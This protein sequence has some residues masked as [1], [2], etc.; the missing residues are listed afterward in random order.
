MQ[1]N[2]MK[3]IAEIWILNWKVAPPTILIYIGYGCYLDYICINS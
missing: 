1:N 2:S 3:V